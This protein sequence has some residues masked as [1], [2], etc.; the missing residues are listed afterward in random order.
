MLL[1]N[2][3][4]L[5]RTFGVSEPT[6][7]KWLVEGAPF[8][9]GGS[10]GVAYEFD[11]DAV[12]AWRDEVEQRER[13]LASERE[14]AIRQ[15]Q[16]EL[17]GEQTFMPEGMSQDDIGKYLDNLRLFEVVKRQR[18]EVIER[19]VVRN[20]FQAVF[21]V[22][23]Q[24]VLGWATTLSKTA[25]LSPEQQQAAETLGRGTL[26]AMWRQIKDQD[27]RPAIDGDAI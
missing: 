4:E 24:H 23:R 19:A 17:F 15:K 27:L 26:A 22:L 20:E 11:V 25:G 12:K 14:A 16:A 10:N 6:V 8:V 5:A 13:D 9:K 18:G 1:V 7:S 2:K 3:A 21:N